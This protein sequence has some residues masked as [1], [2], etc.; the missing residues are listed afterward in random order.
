ML[1]AVLLDRPGSGGGTRGWAD[2]P[3]ASAHGAGADVGV[4]KESAL[5]HLWRL[6]AEAGR[7]LSKALVVKS[8]HI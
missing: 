6:L 5:G 2:A 4:Y 7:T 1:G 3:H 8:L